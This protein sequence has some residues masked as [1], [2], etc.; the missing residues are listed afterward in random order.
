MTK[1]EKDPKILSVKLGTKHLAIA[2]LEGQDLLY[3]G[4]KRIRHKKISEEKALKNLR[5]I[6]YGLIDF[7]SPDVMAMEEIFYTQSR[8]SNLLNR[9]IR[10]VERGWQREKYQSLF[11]FPD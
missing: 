8:K 4:N 1:E 7:W 3:W 2:V 10:E 9:L 6:L 5:D 11:L